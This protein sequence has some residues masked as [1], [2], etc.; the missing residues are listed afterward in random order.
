MNEHSDRDKTEPPARDERVQRYAEAL[1]WRRDAESGAIRAMLDEQVQRVM[2]VADAEQAEL[3]AEV[4][5]WREKAQESGAAYANANSK[6]H[7]ELD[8]ANRLERLADTLAGKAVNLED[9]AR[10]AEAEAAKLADKVA[11]VEAALDVPSNHSDTCDSLS[12]CSSC[13]LECDCHVSTFRAALDG[14]TTAS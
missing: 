6:H 4:E 12:S 2:A 9:R 5:R 11:R 13:D 14:P 1:G 8:R 10:A 3:R 7:E